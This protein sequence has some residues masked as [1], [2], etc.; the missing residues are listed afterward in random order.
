MALTI[1]D[2]KQIVL[3]SQ[4][5][6]SLLNLLKKIFPNV[7]FTY[8]YVKSSSAFDLPIINKPG[9]ILLNLP[10]NVVINILESNQLQKSN[11]PILV[12]LDTTDDFIINKLINLGATH[13]VDIELSIKSLLQAVRDCLRIFQLQQKHNESLIKINSQL[14]K[15]NK[16]FELFTYIISH[17][18]KAP[19]RAINNLSEWIAEDL[20]ET[21]ENISPEIFKNLELLKGRVKRLTAL[22]DAILQYS[23]IGRIKLA[24]ETIDLNLLLPEIVSLIDKAPEFTISIQANMPKLIAEVERISQVF[25]HLIKNA[26]QFHNRSDGKIEIFAIDKTTHYEF[27]IKDDG[28]GIA[29]EYHEKIFGI[30]QT[31]AARDKIETT[32]IGLAI[33]KKILESY[34][35]TISVSSAPGQGSTFKF[36]WPKLANDEGNK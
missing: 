22:I 18:L 33:V 20:T 34:G 32:G 26:I 17:D 5:N 24:K 36:C 29:T 7:E 35:A 9:I 1:V 3:F 21:K 25:T 15:T 14:D 13:C 16:E 6:E 30:F 8:T 10:N 31:L 11:L 28:P 4:T 23:R 27:F 19:L 12:I 2:I